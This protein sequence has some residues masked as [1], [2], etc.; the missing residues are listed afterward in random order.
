MGGST[1]CGEIIERIDGS[2]GSYAFCRVA[3]IGIRNRKELGRLEGLIGVRQGGVRR[4][5]SPGTSLACPTP[6]NPR[7]AKHTLI[8][9]IASRSYAIFSRKQRE[10][11]RAGEGSKGGFC[12]GG[13]LN[14]SVL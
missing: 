9:G 2:V 5:A 3:L 11:E 6:I 7:L 10:L 14:R 8:E 4:I 1:L 13:S 12:G